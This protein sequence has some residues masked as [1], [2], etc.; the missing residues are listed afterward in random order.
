[1]FESYT[2]TCI[3]VLALVIVIEPTQGQKKTIHRFLVA[4]GQLRPFSVRSC[5][6]VGIKSTVVRG[7]LCPCICTQFIT[8]ADS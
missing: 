1:M 7:F 8:W 4:R 3:G 6:S 5:R 2:L